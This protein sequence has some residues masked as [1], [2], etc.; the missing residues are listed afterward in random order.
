M[1]EQEPGKAKVLPMVT[2]GTQ[3]QQLPYHVELWTRTDSNSVDRL[4]AQASSATLA[5]AIFH[6]ARSEH[7]DR[8][9]TLRRGGKLIADSAE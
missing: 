8:R 6:A 3:H 4:L 1:I 2:S 9:I 7:P 5:L